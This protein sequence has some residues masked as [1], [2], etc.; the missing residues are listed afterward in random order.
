MTDVD[1]LFAT[2]FSKVADFAFDENVAR[3]FPDMIKRSVPGYPTIIESIGLIAAQYAQPNSLIYDLGCSLGAATQ[4]IRRH[5]SS[6]GCRILAIDNAQAMV[7]RCQEYLTA[8]DAM[9]EEAIPAQVT[10][11][12]IVGYP[13]E[14]CSVVVLNFT[15]Q[16][17]KPEER[18]ALLAAIRHALLPG[19][20]LILSEK[21]HFDDDNTQQSL[22]QLHYAF[23][24]ANGYSELEIAQKRSAI[25]NV[26]LPDT[27]EQHQ[28][29]LANA[30]FSHS[31]IWFQCLNFCSMI[32]HT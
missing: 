15:L 23:K 26:M 19:G 18:L 2:P 32:A 27:L 11:G 17:V 30:G 28:R 20:I 12:D 4:S 29:R 13:L 5:V 10:A 21:L 16:F 9:L 3:V 14:S 25:E 8:Q 7:E 1:N 22:E 31:H 6:E 24:R